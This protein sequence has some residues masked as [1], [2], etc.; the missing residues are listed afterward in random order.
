MYLPLTNII[1]YF[2]TREIVSALFVIIIP[3]WDNIIMLLIIYIRLKQVNTITIYKQ[4]L[5][6]TLEIR[7]NPDVFK[8]TSLALL[9][10]IKL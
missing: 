4:K 1:F 2:S 6:K 10:N 8:A 3:L 7:V 5:L 9:T